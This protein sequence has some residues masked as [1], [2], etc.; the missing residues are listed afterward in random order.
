M[1]ISV[2][3]GGSVLHHGDI[4]R[5]SSNEYS[6]QDYQWTV[7]S[8]DSSTVTAHS[9]H[10]L[11]I[12]ACHVLATNLILMTERSIVDIR[13]TLTCIAR[14]R[15]ADKDNGAMTTAAAVSVNYV[16]TINDIDRLCS[17]GDREEWLSGTTSIVITGMFFL[18]KIFTTSSR[19]R[20]FQVYKNQ[21]SSCFC[22]HFFLA[23]FLIVQLPHRYVYSV[24]RCNLN[25][26][27]YVSTQPELR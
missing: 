10:L 26:Q 13:V 9:G 11:T 4:V 16:M 1:V 15:V 6:L 20:W 22:W 18:V 24:H 7:T 25:L 27:L 8:A 5:C 21:C 3:G 12:D 23:Y 2:P 14:G 19:D 17:T